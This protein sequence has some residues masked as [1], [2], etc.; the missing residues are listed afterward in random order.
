MSNYNII[1]FKK[2]DGSIYGINYKTYNCCKDEKLYTGNNELIYLLPERYKQY[3]ERAMDILGSL[4]YADENME[5]EISKY[6]PQKIELVQTEDN[7][8]ILKIKKSIDVL[9]LKDLYNY[10]EGLIPVKHVAWIISGLY[11][12]SC[13][14]EFAELTHGGITL[15]NTFVSPYYHSVCLFG[16]WWNTCPKKYSKYSKSNIDLKAIKTLGRILLGSEDKGKTLPNREAIPDALYNWATTES[17]FKT[18]Y[19]AYSHWNFVLE[20]SFGSKKFIPLDIDN[21]EFYEQLNV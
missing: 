11:N 4:N 3:C 5:K 15:E 18:A 9:S 12:L 6:F 20:E 13:Y 7:Q 19:D 21:D 14:F 2:A 17:S 16:G 1:N 8:C 10:F